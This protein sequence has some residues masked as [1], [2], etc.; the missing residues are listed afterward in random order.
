MSSSSIATDFL[1]P[2]QQDEEIGRLGPYRVVGLLGKGGMGQVFRAEDTRLKRTVAL[3]VMNARFAALPHSRQ[4][5]LEE[6]R[7]MA[8]VDHDNV[9]T[10][11]EVGQKNN[12]PFMAM[13]LL[14]GETLE[15]QLLN[16]R[17]FSID[18]VLAIAEQTAAGLDAAHARGITHR[19]IKP[20][21]LWVQSPGER[22]KI[23]DFGLALAGSGVDQLSD[24]GSVVGTPGYLSPEQAR[25]EPVDDRTDL[26]ALGVVM[27]ELC[28]GQLPLVAR[29]VPSHLISIICHDP[30]PLG[31]MRPDVPAPLSDLVMK[32][33]SKEPS[34]RIATAA[35]LTETL[36][37][38]RD[39]VARQRQQD[40][41]IVVAE[42]G[43]GA[44]AAAGRRQAPARAGQGGQ[45]NGTPQG[46]EGDA[47]PKWQWISAASALAL[48]ILIVGVWLWRRSGRRVASAPRVVA[49]TSERREPSTSPDEP[50][51]ILSEALRPLAIDEKIVGDKDVPAGT[52]ARFR[53]ELA[54]RAESAE[55]D[56]RIRFRGASRVARLQLFLQQQGKLKAPAPVFPVYFSAKQL[57]APGET[58]SVEVPMQTYRMDEGEYQLFAELQT[59]AGGRVDAAET[60]LRVVENLMEGDLLG[61]ETIRTFDGDG[62]DSFV[63]K[64]D[65][66]AFGSRHD[67][68]LLDHR[69][70][71]AYA[72]VRF[73]LGSLV[74]EPTP[75]SLQRIDRA[76]L[77]LTVADE[78]PSKKTAVRVY[79]W[80]PAEQGS[81]VESQAGV[82]PDGWAERGAAALT[83]E[84]LPDLKTSGRFVSLGRLEIDNSR[85]VLKEK[86]DRVRFVS[87][88][89]DDF[90]RQADGPVVSMLLVPEDSS[91]KPL[92]LVA[93]EGAP[94]MAPALAIRWKD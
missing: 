69:G 31:E 57:P 81:G 84:S 17:Q 59:P 23:L 1:E 25:N 13:E 20:A 72:V 82:T 18:E 10:I 43:G 58:K 92:R 27:Y 77:S 90:L 91:S 47:I 28:C 45:G 19:D 94:E 53:I 40:L 64:G 49:E 3:K 33:L 89:L 54:N 80:V 24:V 5:F 36:G 16:G 55:S 73:D 14:Q 6:A 70:D 71:Q 2:P 41:S 78:S 83:W 35:Q 26:Y 8:A 62:A 61:F 66:E 65:S 52:T 22:I 15:T 68:Q 87:K 37:E 21:N 11:F 93:K 56:P 9:A 39:A 86:P 29:D 75:E 44:G 60:T 32:L 50:P 46:E 85:N 42:D 7:S 51:A 4:R 48:I 79:G 63:R 38:V 76:A 88:L 74:E 12:T 30:V 34:D 67:L